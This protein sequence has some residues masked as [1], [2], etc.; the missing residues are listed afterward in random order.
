MCKRVDLNQAKSTCFQKKTQSWV[1]IK[2]KQILDQG[3]YI[4]E[5]QKNILVKINII[6]THI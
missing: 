6:Y 1:N 2:W 5:F 4:L 3:E